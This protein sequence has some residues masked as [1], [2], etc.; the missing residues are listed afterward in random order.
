MPLKESEAIVLRT[1]P[2][3]E[4]DRLVSFL[5]RQS[6]R[7]R[8]VARGARLPKSRFGS[9]L[10]MLA[11]IR[12]WY[13][14]R[15]TRELVRINQCELIESFMDVHRDY[16]SS[17]GLALVSEIT[18][19]VLGEREAADAQFRLIL[20]TARA[21]RVHGA[22]QAVLAYFGL[23]TAKLGG[24]L[25][26]LNRCSSCGRDFAVEAAY[27]APGF[28]ELYCSGCRGDWSKQISKE[29][30]SIGGIALTGTLDRLLKENPASGPTREILSYALDVLEHHMEKKLI[31]RKTFEIG[32][33]GAV[34][35]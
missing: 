3:G 13:F 16:A 19:S 14:E 27:H 35:I 21:I 5:D 7:V 32:E 29:A 12:I 26:P 34:E 22:S 20:L 28:A 25:G 30:L 31:S 9:T 18:D 1:F 23:W 11:Y 10:E 17:V 4:G 6:G 8:G 15:E 2:L 24:W 33:S